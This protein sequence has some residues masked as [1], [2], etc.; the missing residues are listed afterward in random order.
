MSAQWVLSVREEHRQL[1]RREN[2]VGC[3]AE[4]H[5]PQAALCVGAFD[6]QVCALRSGLREND[7]TW[8]LSVSTDCL[9]GRSDAMGFQVSERVLGGG[10]WDNVA[11]DGQQ[12]NAL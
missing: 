10:T 12:H 11:F 5:L 9:L 3:A 7:L 2:V 1:G 4:D 8:A 6:Q